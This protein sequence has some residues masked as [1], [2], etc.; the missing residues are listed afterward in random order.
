MQLLINAELGKLTSSLELA[1]RGY[2]DAKRREQITLNCVAPD[3]LPLQIAEVYH[4]LYPDKG[5]DRIEKRKQDAVFFEKHCKVRVAVE[6]SRLAGGFCV[7]D[8]ELVAF[9][10]HAHGKGTWLLDHAVNLGAV[11]LNTFDVPH[12]LAL[13]ESRGFRNMLRKPNHTPGGPDVIYMELQKV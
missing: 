3:V 13:Y 2:S 5:L 9:H 8:G 10:S 7:L 1:R 4:R 6:D 11:R 12:L